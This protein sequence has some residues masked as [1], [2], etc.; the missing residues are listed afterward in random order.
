M[1]RK[2]LL[3]RFGWALVPAI[4]V[5]VLPA[6]VRADD[7][8]EKKSEAEKL[9]L[10][11]KERPTNLREADRSDFEDFMKH[12]TVM[13]I[14]DVATMGRGSGS[15]A[16][17][18]RNGLIVTNNHVV[19]MTHGRSA[20]ERAQMFRTMTKPSYYVLVYDGKDA[21]GKPRKFIYDC[22]LK[23]QLESADLALL[24]INS[25]TKDGEEKI[26]SS[27][28]YLRFV[29]NDELKDDMKVVITGFPGG[30]RRGTDSVQT[31]GFVTELL[32]TSSGSV[33]YIE[34]D[35]EVH[36]GN[37]GGPVTDPAGRLVGVATHKRFE[38]G[39]KDRSGA[40]PINI[41]RQF[42]Y[43]GFNQDRMDDF[44]DVFPFIDV[45]VNHAG[46]TEIPQF[47]R[48][49]E[50]NE[51]RLRWP[52]GTTRI[53]EL[54]TEQVSV[55]TPVGHFQLDLDH[56]G[57]IFLDG[58]QRQF[59][60]LVL[61]G[62]DQLLALSRD[63]ALDVTVGGN[64]QELP[65]WELESVAL[66]K[67][68][69][70]VPQ[71][72]GQG[73]QFAGVGCELNLSNVS[74]DIEISGSRYPLSDVERITANMDERVQIVET[75]K[76]EVIKGRISDQ[77]IQADVTWSDH[78]V[79]I[80][81]RNVATAARVRE[82][83]W[84]RVAAKGRLLTE[85]IG[86]PATDQ[87]EILT[88]T[89][90]S[91][92]WE[93]A[94]ALLDDIEHPERT[95]RQVIE[96]TKLLEAIY[97]LRAGEFK[98]AKRMF[99]Q[100]DRSRYVGQVAGAYRLVLEQYPDGKY[101]GRSLTKPEI[102]WLA[103][104]EAARLLID[105]AHKRLAETAELDQI[106]KKRELDDLEEKL[107]VVDYLEPGIAQ[108]ALLETLSQTY[109]AYVDD[110]LRFIEDYNEVVRKHNREPSRLG[111]RRYRQE[112]RA[113][114]GRFDRVV[115]RLDKIEERIRDLAGGFVIPPPELPKQ[116]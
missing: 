69:D 90:D 68:L 97:K 89:L 13:V 103:S 85:R 22:T 64:R 106:Q 82:V 31:I 100:L 8:K 19:D 73:V 71:R 27:P 32:K 98:E 81:F 59:A 33:S 17:I 44:A 6:T 23:H 39:E 52:D 14:T 87:I 72:T 45:F 18:N 112:L 75:V 88:E 86:D 70:L 114:E 20:Q 57:Y 56:V 108:S 9:D 12:A 46:M 62:G 78:P 115:R 104:T 66:P 40:V 35:A 55:K 65:L 111:R 51:V 25:I 26:I 47:D 93:M 50:D 28:N 77:P 60:S 109:Q 63:I 21:N 24:Q 113:I 11:L 4:L 102:L 101:K 30:E 99:A 83:D 48:N 7:E 80:Q 94:G 16:F 43:S 36:P 5:L 92:D 110:A 41:V 79:E 49:V 76:G 116:D 84:R 96:Q 10:T 1:M 58:E 67:N 38:T 95:P 2:P 54:H 74:G 3:K 61:D 42:V 15:G 105:R 53:G 37:S 34:T 107:T 91:P 29:E